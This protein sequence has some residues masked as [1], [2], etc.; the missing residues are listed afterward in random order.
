MERKYRIFIV[1]DEDSIREIEAYILRKEGYEVEKFERGEPF[2]ERLGTEIPD[3]IMLDIMLPGMDG[4]E[5]LREVKHFSR[6]SEVPVIM[7]TAKSDDIDLIRGLESG[8]D[9]Y[10]AKPLNYPVLLAR[11]QALLRRTR[12]DVV[13]GHFEYKDITVDQSMRMATIAGERMELSEKEF[14]LLMTFVKNAPMPVSRDQLMNEIWGGDFAGESRTLDMHVNRLRKKLSGAE[15]R[16][17]TV[18]GKGYKLE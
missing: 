12:A 16:L 18:W 15:A 5:V 2:L 6:A 1:E 14:A 7:A 17:T 4:I 11:I 10:V 9:D 8:A 13:K 3:L